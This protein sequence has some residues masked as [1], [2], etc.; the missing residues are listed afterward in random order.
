MGRLECVLRAALPGQPER[1]TQLD[2]AIR[3]PLP[4]NTAVGLL[5]AGPDA[6]T[7]LAGALLAGVLAARR[8]HRVLAVAAAAGE[9]SITRQAGLAGAATSS[10]D[11]IS[12]RS[13]ATTGEQASAGLA[14]SDGGVWCLD[15]AGDPS[16]WWQGVAPINRFF[17]FVVT[18]WGSPADAGDAR[19]TSAV[20]LVVTA[21]RRDCLQAG[22]DLVAQMTTPAVAPLLVVHDTATGTERG[23]REATAANDGL[24]L[25]DDPGLRRVPDGPGRG[26]RYGTNRAVL[27]LA[28]AVV[29][30]GATRTLEGARR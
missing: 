19:A 27:E 2:E 4:L 8:P 11:A 24:W 28:A 29:T 16:G 7:A 30:A 26:L 23:L 12:R 20:L 3:A 22:V 6:P 5:G 18:D 14:R 10:D 17:D 21:A 25:P 1:L 13:T 9:P 15:L